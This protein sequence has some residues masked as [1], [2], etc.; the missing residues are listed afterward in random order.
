MWPYDIKFH[1]KI[2]NMKLEMERSK[3]RQQW[4]KTTKFLKRNQLRIGTWNALI[5]TAHLGFYVH[6][7]QT[8]H[9]EITK[10]LQLTCCVCLVK[11]TSQG[12][13]QFIRMACM[14]LLLY[15]KGNPIHPTWKKKPSV[16]PIYLRKGSNTCQSLTVG[17][18]GGSAW[19][20]NLLL[21]ILSLL[22]TATQC[23]PLCNATTFAFVLPPCY[24]HT[25][26]P[27][28]FKRSSSDSTAE[29]LRS[30][31]RLSDWPNQL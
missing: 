27:D 23:W 17:N 8:M 15:K 31:D 25:P 9:C 3:T 10:F 22:I 19:Q 16:C 7:T 21:R 13:E 11:R 18:V 26:C 29:Q 24:I 4:R 30:V 28:R 2:L 1:V 5:F 20:V 12:K 14:L 6:C